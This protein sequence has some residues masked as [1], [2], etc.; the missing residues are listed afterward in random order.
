MKKVVISGS[1]ALFPII[2]KWNKYWEERG[3]QVAAYPEP[4]EADNFTELYPSIHT[5]F[6]R[7][8]AEADVHFIANED[9][10][11]VI[12]YIGNGVYAE[13]AFRVGLNLTRNQKVPVILL[14]APGEDSHFFDDLKVWMELDWVQLF[15]K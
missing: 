10:N 3:Y 11:G 5:D 2:K 6:Y 15:E 12:G 9:K 13:I 7:K 1:S 8:L 4:I 14:K